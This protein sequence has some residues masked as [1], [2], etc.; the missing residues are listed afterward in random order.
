MHFSECDSALKY[1]CGR[2]SF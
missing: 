1:V 2:T